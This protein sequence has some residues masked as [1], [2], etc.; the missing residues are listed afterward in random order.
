MKIKHKMYMKILVRINKCLTIV[1]IL[2]SKMKEETADVAI[3]EF[4]GLKPKM[5]S[6]LVDV[7]AS[8]IHKE[9]KHVFLNKKSFRHMIKR[10]QSKDHRIGT[11]EINKISL[12]CSD[13]EIY[14]KQ[15]IS[16]WL[17]ELII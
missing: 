9:Y 4:V 8:I 16:H 6:F 7:V 14:I 3:K 12:S 15:W 2:L 11:Y 13:H 17:S 1:I 5:Y 10:I